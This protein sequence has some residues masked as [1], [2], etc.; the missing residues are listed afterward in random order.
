MKEKQKQNKITQKHKNS[1]RTQRKPKKRTTPSKS[2]IPKQVVEQVCGLNDPF[3]VHATTARYTE[4]GYNR[5][6]TLPYRGIDY[7]VSNG[8]GE[9][10]A[11]FL[12]S[13]LDWKITPATVSFP[14]V[15]YVGKLFN[16]TPYLSNV[17]NFRIVSAGMT[18]TCISTRLNTAGTCHVRSFGTK[19]SNQLINV[20]PLTFN[21][22][23]VIDFP[24]VP[25]ATTTLAFKRVDNTA[26]LLF[27][28]DEV[29]TAGLNVNTWSS[30]GWGPIHIYFNGMPINTT[31]FEIKYFLN[32]EV[33]LGDSNALQQLAK[34][35]PP[36]NPNITNLSNMVSSETK[37]FVIG[38]IETYGKQVIQQTLR[39]AAASGLNFMRSVGP[40]ALTMA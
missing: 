2:T 29:A 4:M 9:Q 19:D 14:A 6:L 34:M 32:Y 11:L 8:F 35:T 3:C 20:D 36:D 13:F 23:E 18:L 15:S 21:A 10:A 30:P 40:L 39:S 26:P 33:V 37:A 25:G 17:E 16:G 28:P 27:K 1:D 5:T 38:N 7:L 24:I 22:L 31:T 12:P